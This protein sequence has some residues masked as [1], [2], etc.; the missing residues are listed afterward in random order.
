LRQRAQRLGVKV[1]PLQAGRR[2]QYAGVQVEVLA[3]A[4]E[5]ET[6]ASARN[7]DSLVLRLAYGR[8]SFL[9]AGDIDRRIEAELLERSLIG[10]SQVLKV[11]HHGG[12]GSSSAPFL[13]AALPAVAI[14]S[15]GFENSY[16]MPSA[17][18]LERLR[19]R[20]VA[21]LRTDLW[22]LVTVRSDGLRLSLDTMRW[23]GQRL[24]LE[25]VTY[26]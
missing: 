11:A 10:K 22:G 3:P 13:E 2:F 7:N 8:H 9:L 20:R 14:I 24:H 1:V 18:V 26:H 6:G 5:Y 23:M 25:P 16:G 15:A 19:E 12:K 17:E 4:P 21:V